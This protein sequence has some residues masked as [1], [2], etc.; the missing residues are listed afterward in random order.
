[1][2]REGENRYKE[3]RGM[4]FNMGIP[5]KGKINWRMDNREEV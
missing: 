1:L 2:R 3:K 4:K 5:T